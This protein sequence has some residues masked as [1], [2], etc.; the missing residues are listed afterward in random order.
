MHFREKRGT[1]TN[2]NYCEIKGLG[3]CFLRLAEGRSTCKRKTRLKISQCI[4]SDSSLAKD[5]YFH[6]VSRVN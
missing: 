5:S 6:V 4:N 2:E 1:T 3:F